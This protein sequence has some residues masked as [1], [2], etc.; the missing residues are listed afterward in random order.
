MTLLSSRHTDFSALTK[1]FKPASGA[2]LG[3]V[4]NIFSH[5]SPDGEGFDVRTYHRIVETFKYAYAQVGGARVAGRH[6]PM[7]LCISAI[8]SSTF[9]HH[10]ACAA[11]KA[12]GSLLLGQLRYK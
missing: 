7:A 11:F 2:V 1:I 6:G 8:K 4:L 12:R 10:H 3:M 5:F 9:D